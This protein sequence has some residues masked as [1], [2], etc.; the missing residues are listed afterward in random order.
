MRIPFMLLL[1]AFG[2]QPILAQADPATSQV[3]AKNGF[4][5]LHAVPL[6]SSTFRAVDSEYSVRP[7][8]WGTRPRFPAGESPEAYSAQIESMAGTS[9]LK[10]S[11]T[12]L[13]D[14]RW[15][16][17]KDYK[18]VYPETSWASRSELDAAGNYN[19]GYSGA[20]LVRLYVQ[21]SSP[22]ANEVEVFYFQTQVMLRL[23]GLAKI[24]VL[25]RDNIERIVRTGRVKDGW[26]DPQR[27][28]RPLD[29]SGFETAGGYYGN[30]SAKQAD[31]LSGIVAY[32]SSNF[33]I[34]ETQRD[35]WQRK[36]NEQLESSRAQ[37][38]RL[39]RESA[40]RAR[41]QEE[42]LRVKQERER[43]QRDRD[44]RSI[45]QRG[46]ANEGLDSRHNNDP[47]LWVPEACVNS[48]TETCY[49][50]FWIRQSEVDRYI[51]EH[52]GSQ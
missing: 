28:G 15:Y 16:G 29:P 17:N 43:E 11:A 9:L 20:T 18:N 34:L 30:Q 22:N 8:T 36:M 47:W 41:M 40:E 1:L 35:S 46:R 6:G 10:A 2:C 23:A 21:R 19:Y 7:G 25:T 44:R 12:W 51:D 31:I 14:V 33:G 52:G 45:E 49:P 38:E 3:W 42:L 32:E 39:A 13:N 27:Y 5:P 4:Q 37:A 26:G 24:L 50:G 48:G